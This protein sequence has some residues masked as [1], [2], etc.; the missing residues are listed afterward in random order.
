MLTNQPLVSVIVNCHNGEKYLREALDTIFAQTYKYFEII[1]WDNASSDRSSYIA[2]SFQSIDS[3]L[4]YFY[5]DKTI[6][7]GEARV[8]AINES[9]GKLLSFLDCDDL[10]LPSKLEKQV[11]LFVK[12][13]DKVGFIYSR[14]SVISEHGE[15]IGEINNLKNKLRIGDIFGELV[16]K[17]FIPFVSVLVSKKKYYEVGGFPEAYKNSTDYDLFLKLSY[18]HQVLAVDEILCKY[19]EH[20]NNRSHLQYVIGAKEGLKS[21]SNFLPDP[22]AEI[23]LK[24]Q[25]I[26]LTLAYV[27]D[28]SYRN[29]F[30]LLIKH[31]G[32][33]ILFKRL[34]DKVRI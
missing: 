20:S 26:Q 14:C 28:K 9:S 8:L 19:R 24:Y 33:L 25:Y 22:R 34:V 5:V 29:A 2:K 16:K 10:W 32:F 13:Q 30:N 31:G 1:F 4:K 7:L 11:E 17:N 23:G 6:P 18:E 3:R 15:K 12:N 27:K 21:V